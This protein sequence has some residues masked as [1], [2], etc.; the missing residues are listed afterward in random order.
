M[1]L[2]LILVYVIVII[3][4]FNVFTVLVKTVYVLIQVLIIK[5]LL[6]FTQYNLNDFHV[7]V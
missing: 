3:I 5:D 4:I 2:F 1:N 6:K 7:K